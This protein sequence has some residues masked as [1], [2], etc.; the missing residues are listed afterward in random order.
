M[1]RTVLV[2]V[3]GFVV[4]F[5]VATLGNFLIRVLLPGYAAVELSMAFTLAMLIARLLL[6]FVSSFVAGLASSAVAQGK[7]AAVHVFAAV[8]LLFFLVIHFNLWSKF[9]LWYH[10]AFLGSVAPLALLG[11]AAQRRMHPSAR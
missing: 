3:V 5:I 8:L 6:G 1:I 2:V 7:P 9:P 10:V 4:W 11:A